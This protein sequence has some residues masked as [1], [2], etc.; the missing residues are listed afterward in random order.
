MISSSGRCVRAQATFSR[1][2]MPPEYFFD[3]LVRV[4]READ[5]LE[6]LRDPVLQLLRRAGR[7]G[8]RRTARFSRADRSSKI[9]I[10]WVTSPMRRLMSM[11]PG[12]CGLPNTSTAPESMPIRPAQRPDGRRLAGAVGPEEAQD[13]ALRDL[14][15]HVVQRQGGPEALHHVAQGGDGLRFS[16]SIR[17]WMEGSRHRHGVW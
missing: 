8:R 7:R 6:R 11:T 15:V 16:A 9:V 13:L 10:S 17:P 14:E 12:R 3:P 2:F 5:E 4:L 1:R